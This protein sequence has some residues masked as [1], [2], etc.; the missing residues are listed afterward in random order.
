MSADPP[1]ERTPPTRDAALRRTVD[2]LE[3]A[4]DEAL[5][6]DPARAALATGL[7]RTLGRP[8]AAREPAARRL[9]VCHRFADAIGRAAA[10]AHEGSGVGAARASPAAC[11]ALAR[12]LAVLEPSLRWYRRIGSEAVGGPFHDG[13]ANAFLIGGPDG[14][15]ARDDVAIGLSLVAPGIRY[16]DHSHPPEELYLVLSG[17]A[18]QNA[19]T[20]WFEPGI[21]T[22]VHNPPG[23]VHAM[24]S[25]AEPLLAVWCL[26]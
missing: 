14:L 6:D 1:V 4:F 5:R 25:G 21:G 8:G 15:E 19:E 24:R 2:A 3:R 16:P 18:W 26:L 22:T 11:A 23:I 17:G 9:P 7:F 20:P 10:A 13:H 12:C